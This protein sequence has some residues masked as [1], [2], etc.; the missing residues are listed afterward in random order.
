MLRFLLFLLFIYSALAQNPLKK[1]KRVDGIYTRYALQNNVKDKFSS[2]V[3]IIVDDEVI[4]SG[5]LISEDGLIVTK[6]SELPETFLIQLNDGAL[7]KPE[8]IAKDKG[9]DLSL[10]KII[11]QD[12]LSFIEFI[13]EVK[14]EQSDWLI[15]ILPDNRSK[16]G[17]SSAK[18]RNITKASGVLGVLLGKETKQGVVVNQVINDGPAHLAGIQNGDIIK[19]IDKTPVFSH[20]AVLNAL[21]GRAPGDEIAV[22][23]TNASKDL[24]KKI[25][26]GDR[27]IT[28]GM[29]NR[30]LEMSGTVSKRVDGFKNI[31]QHDS[32]LSCNDICTPLCD[33]NGNVAGLN[34]AKVN[35]SEVYALPNSE[36]KA[37]IKRLK[38]QHQDEKSQITSLQ[39][40]SF[41]ELHSVQNTIKKLLNKSKIAT[42]ALEVNGASGS[43]VIISEDGYI[44]TA[45]HISGTPKTPVRVYMHDGKI[46]NAESL[47][48]FPK[49]DIGLVKISDPVGKKLP[50][51]K[52]ANSQN[53]DVG[54]W[55]YAL[56]HP[57]GFIKNRGAVIRVGKLID[58]Q[59]H[60]IWT[61]CTLL[62]GDSGGPL[63]NLKGEVIGVNSRIFDNSDENIH[64]PA[65]LVIMNW[66]EL[67]KGKVIDSK[68]VTPFLGVTTKSNGIGIKVTKVIEKSSA[69]RAGILKGDIILSLN[70]TP[71]MSTA[72]LVTALQGKNVGDE[73][74]L[75]L[76]RDGE[77]LQLKAILGIKP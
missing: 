20:E 11:S 76:T 13:D 5:V 75:N 38:S 47:G 31:I 30:N 9:S 62:G 61:D 63:F 44:F 39:S 34:I 64:G 33:I 25:K 29:F 70:H 55:C 37:A 1:S 45:A 56:G 3:K 16:I 67:I 66:S 19:E 46:Y 57:N 21:K 68:Q 60:L 59:P 41:E 10:L 23:L 35:R 43:G 36:V 15:S 50:Y 24:T 74:S 71:I 28:F 65:D 14:V 22:K 17:I 48:V 26:L 69:S 12:K 72:E 6:T 77:E 53:S 49:A 27:S 42:V 18:R 58:I 54:D 32:S 4:S 2:T 51:V 7:H 52:M 8:V 73:I 40:I